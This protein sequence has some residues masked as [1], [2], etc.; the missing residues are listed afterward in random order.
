[1]GSSA[2]KS[3]KNS[4]EDNWTRQTQ[5]QDE[6]E[7]PIVGMVCFH[8]VQQWRVC[9]WRKIVFV[10]LDIYFVLFCIYSHSNTL[11]PWPN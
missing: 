2:T 9:Y 5:S 3:A 6:T 7:V 4:G 8:A 1:M 11:L 10:S